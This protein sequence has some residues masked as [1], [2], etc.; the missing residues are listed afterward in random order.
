MIVIRI[1]R[2]T[3]TRTEIAR[4][5][6]PRDVTLDRAAGAIARLLVKGNLRT[7]NGVA[8]GKEAAS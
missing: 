3:K 8:D 6:D 1:D 5:A 2:K 4:Y 7:D